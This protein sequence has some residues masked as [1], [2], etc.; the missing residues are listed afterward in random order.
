M[1]ITFLGTGMLTAKSGSTSFVVDDHILFDIGN[2]VTDA[3]VENGLDTKNIDTIVVSH[4]HTDHFGDI[5]YFV[6]KRYL[7]G[8]TNSELKIIGPVGTQEKVE[9]LYKIMNFDI[10]GGELLN[11][12]KIK[13]IELDNGNEYQGEGFSL[14][15]FNV[16]HGKS[17]CLG[18]VFANSQGM[19]GYSGD[20]AYTQEIIENIPNADN[21]VI[22][23]NDIDEFKGWH[24]GLKNIE[25]LAAKHTD[26]DFYVVHRRDKEYT[27]P[28]T[29][30]HLPN[31]GD[32]VE[33]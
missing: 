14:K 2:G 26:I 32:S 29:N 28:L 17:R 27:T 10:A 12:N 23:A 3:L 8:E 15:A 5:M 4:F 31:D 13:Y 1:K 21:W 22:E 11:I 25:E 6:T 30:I 9:G 19:L 16:I 33:V 18:Y 20:S 7:L 24:I